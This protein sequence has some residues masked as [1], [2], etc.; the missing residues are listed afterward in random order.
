MTNKEKYNLFLSS[1]KENIPIFMQSWW[2]D[3]V[4]EKNWDVL[5][6]ENEDEIVAAMPYCMKK[7]YNMK[8]IMPP[9]LT[10]FCG[11]YIKKEK[12]GD[13]MSYYSFENKVMEE[14]AKKINDL[15]LAFF[16]YTFSPTLLS[17]LGFYW[18]GFSATIRYTYKVNIE[19]IEDCFNSF[20]RKKRGHI[21]KAEKLITVSTQDYDLKEIY[22]ILQETYT[23]QK[24]TIP[25]SFSFFER[26]VNES[27]K[28]NC[29]KLFIAKDDEE[30]INAVLFIVWDNLTCYNLIA[31][32]KE[33]YKANDAI[34]LLVFCA[35]KYA[36]SLNIKDYDME[37]SMIKGVER[38]FREFN[39]KQTPYL[40]ISKYYSSFYKILRKI[41]HRKV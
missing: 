24:T 26:L 9:M 21:R 23:K 27:I 38:Y 3:V 31:G 32:S 1:N 6:M 29:G 36:N 11:I 22:S 25:Y 7:R 13:L 19:N 30:N 37:G 28:R 12:E 15:H 41:K 33:K 39:G 16:A 18:Q 40:F 20:D 35:M 5:L 4:C 34:S 8:T 2:L 10:P 14:F 17:Y